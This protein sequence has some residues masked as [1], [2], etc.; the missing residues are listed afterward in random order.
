MRVIVPGVI[1]AEEAA[2]LASTVGYLD[3]GDDRLVGILER[4]REI[5]PVSLC[6][7]SY[8]RVEQRPD[9]CPW[10]QDTGTAGHMGWCRYTA[11]ILLVSPSGFTGG[12]FYFCDEPD[13]PLF[14]YCD[15]LVWSGGDD[16]VHCVSRNSGERIALL[17]FFGGSEDVGD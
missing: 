12:G 16:N 17:M 8:V 4:V 5:A 11:G 7:G 13:K 2:S 6:E 14:H 15:L 1:T 3:W 9:G 10:H